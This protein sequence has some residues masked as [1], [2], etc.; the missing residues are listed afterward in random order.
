MACWRF[1]GDFFSLG[2]L[3]SL[4][5]FRF[6]KD[7]GFAGAHGRHL[8]GYA[9]RSGSRLPC[10]SIK[11]KGNPWVNCSCSSRIRSVNLALFCNEDQWV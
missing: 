10:R 7:L 1:Y 6:L 11:P 5:V 4:G 2:D 8:A 3:P 9:R